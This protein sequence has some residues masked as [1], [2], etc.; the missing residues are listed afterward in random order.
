[1]L[2]KVA[3]A[4][5]GDPFSGDTTQGPQ[6]SKEQFDTVMSY[7]QAGKDQGAT[8][9]AGGERHGKKGHFIQPT[10]FSDVTD[11]MKV[12]KEEIF[13]TRSGTHASADADR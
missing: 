7:I 2:T 8:L 4:K 10:V 3:A 1:M 13:G 5:L 12:A 6:V 11:D 9:L